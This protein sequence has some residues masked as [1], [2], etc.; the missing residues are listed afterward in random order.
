MSSKSS[1]SQ[2]SGLL[3][4]LLLFMLVLYV[5]VNKC[6]SHVE[7]FSCPPVLNQ[8]KA[9]DTRPTV[10]TSLN[11]ACAV[12]SENIKRYQISVILYHSY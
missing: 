11:K 3:L 12:A 10:S 7:T 4:L 1:L 6:F 9:E 8:Y 5:P 2:I